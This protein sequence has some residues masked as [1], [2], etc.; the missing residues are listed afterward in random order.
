MENIKGR[1]DSLRAHI[2]K[3]YYLGQNVYTLVEVAKSL[4]NRNF[5]SEKGNGVGMNIISLQ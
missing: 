3:K 2:F 1:I 5:T 4:A